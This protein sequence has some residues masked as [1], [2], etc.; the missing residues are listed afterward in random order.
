MKTLVAPHGVS[1]YCVW[2][3]EVWLILDFLQDL[4]HWLSKHCVN[5]LRSRSPKLPSKIPSGSV[6]IVV[7][8][9]EI[10]PLLKDNLTLSLVL[11][12]VLLNPFIL[13]NP[14]HELAY[15]GN[16]LFG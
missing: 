10:P 2:P 3:F 13:I 9:P 4:M 14:I 5:H 15:A 11:L 7:V 16:K 12:L 1:S 8:Q 6:I